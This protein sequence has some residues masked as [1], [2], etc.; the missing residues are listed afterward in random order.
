MPPKDHEG[1]YEDSSEYDDL[2]DQRR[3]PRHFCS[4]YFR[5][6]R[7]QTR[8]D[9][10]IVDEYSEESRPTVRDPDNI[11][12]RQGRM[13][14]KRSR[15]WAAGSHRW[16][17]SMGTDKGVALDKSTRLSVVAAALEAVWKT[18][19]RDVAVPLLSTR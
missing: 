6:R 8:S 11:S 2:M 12:C 10:D 16:N 5:G 4:R 1:R 3:A 15:K 13:V 19:I 14:V 9:P 7:G 17:T 18:F